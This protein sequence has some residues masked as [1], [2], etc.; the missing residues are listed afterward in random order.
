MKATTWTVQRPKTILK[1]YS[2]TQHFTKERDTFQV[3][4]IFFISVKKHNY[5]G[6]T[7]FFNPT[8]VKP[9]A[10]AYQNTLTFDQYHF[11]SRVY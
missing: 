11:N 2:H 1:K 9:T 6:A 4:N 10:P 5:F 7:L 3:N 8:L